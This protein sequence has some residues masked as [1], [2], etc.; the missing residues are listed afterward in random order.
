[1]YQQITRNLIRKAHSSIQEQLRQWHQ[2]AEEIQTYPSPLLR[3]PWSKPW[4]VD[5]F[6]PSLAATCWRSQTKYR[7]Q[8]QIE[9]QN[10]GPETAVL[11]IWLGS[12]NDTSDFFPGPVRNCVTGL[13]RLP[14]LSAPIFRPY[15][16]Q[17]D[18]QKR[19]LKWATATDHP[20]HGITRILSIL[21][22]WWFSKKLMFVANTSG[23]SPF[24]CRC[25]TH[26]DVKVT[27]S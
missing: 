12:D 18:T 11:N 21:R 3:K 26:S 16:I 20:F 17:D 4:W 24:I 9:G 25:S 1:M 8:N 22:K 2:F 14:Y 13:S 6:H 5:L 23:A 7:F 10:Q 15:D 19:Y 27:S